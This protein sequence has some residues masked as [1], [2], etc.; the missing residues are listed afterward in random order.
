MQS[1]NIIDQTR[2][3]SDITAWDKNDQK[4]LVSK[5]RARDIQE[6]IVSK[7][8]DILSFEYE[9]NKVIVPYAMIATP[10]LIQIFQWDG[11]NLEKKY[12]FPSSEVMSIYDQEFSEKR[13]FES[14]LEALVEGWLRDL[15][16][17]WKTENPPKL[18]ELTQIGLV[19]KLSETVQ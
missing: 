12:D 14:Y 10:K 11:E 6:D 18:A 5:V 7:I 19:E 17:N 13:I 3:I 16:Y 1:I 2:E 9:Q 8:K 4:L 15:A